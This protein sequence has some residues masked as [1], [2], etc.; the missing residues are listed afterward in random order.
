MVLNINQVLCEPFVVSCTQHLR[1][2]A[3]RRASIIFVF[4]CVQV[5]AVAV[6]VDWDGLPV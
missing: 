6:K 5:V 2:L 4:Y 3:S 1:C